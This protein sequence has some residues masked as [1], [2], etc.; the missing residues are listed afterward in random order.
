M[1]EV[2]IWCICMWIVKM[3]GIKKIDIWFKIEWNVYI[4]LL[5]IVF[6][7]FFISKFCYEVELYIILFY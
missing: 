3:I 2:V 6:F 1:V 7:I 4:L 5:I